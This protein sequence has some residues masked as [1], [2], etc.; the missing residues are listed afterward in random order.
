MSTPLI[1]NLGH[2]FSLQL[3]NDFTYEDVQHVTIKFQ[4]LGYSQL[5]GEIFYEPSNLGFE[6]TILQ[7]LQW[8]K[9][10]N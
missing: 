5:I 10:E 2:G 1:I 6:K 8:Q 7:Y 9:K 4:K 3:P